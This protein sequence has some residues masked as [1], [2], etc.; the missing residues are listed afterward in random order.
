MNKVIGYDMGGVMSAD[1]VERRQADGNYQLVE[2]FEG[3]I[4]TLASLGLGFGQRNQFVISRAL[5]R[6]SVQA[7]WDLL[8]YWRFFER[9][10]I[11]EGNVHIYEDPVGDP[12]IKGRLAA[13]L[14]LTDYVDDTRAMLDA[15]PRGVER[16][17][18]FPSR[19][20]FKPDD[21]LRPLAQTG[22]RLF[23]TNNWRDLGDLIRAF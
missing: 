13:E 6:V 4:E 11:P 19:R 17:Y 23:C 12:A 10:G 14:G 9:T 7:N 20:K 21:I 22:T 2:P 1:L 16:A 5:D 15:M 18:L 8:R 3:C